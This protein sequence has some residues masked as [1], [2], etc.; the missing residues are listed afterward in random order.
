V[1]VDQARH[2]RQPGGIDRLARRCS[3]QISSDRYDPP[4]DNSHVG[5]LKHDSGRREYSTIRDGKVDGRRRLTTGYSCDR[6]HAQKEDANWIMS[7]KG[8]RTV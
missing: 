3:R 6:K 8:E 7:R 4:I 2:N 1:G 5:P